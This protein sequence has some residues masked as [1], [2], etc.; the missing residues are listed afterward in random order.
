MKSK[1]P[2]FFIFYLCFCGFSGTL[3]ADFFSIEPSYQD[4]TDLASGG[5][6]LT[7]ATHEGMIFSNPAQ[8]A[9][10]PK[11]FKWL[12]TRFSI[13][14]TQSAIDYATG[15]LPQFSAEDIVN[16]LDQLGK[17]DFAIGAGSM[18][19]TFITSNFAI[20]PI[21][22]DFKIGMGFNKFG[23]SKSGTSSFEASLD[24]ENKSGLGLATSI[25]PTSWLSL[26]VTARGLL[27]TDEVVTI[28]IN[29]GAFAAN[30]SAS[31]EAVNSTIASA[32]D[33]LSVSQVVGYDIG[34]LLF[35]QGPVIDYRF[36]LVAR[37]VGGAKITK[38][39]LA[40]IGGNSE[41]IP[42]QSKPQ[43]FDVGV[44]VTLHSSS[45]FIHLAADLRD[46]KNVYETPS[47]KRYAFGLK[48]HLAQWVALAAGVR[49][50]YPSY[51]IEFDA[52]LF[53]LSLAQYTE[54]LGNDPLGKKRK[55]NHISFAMGM[56][57]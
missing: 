8:L 43:A 48:S 18:L 11:I 5:A 26:G 33:A 44:G 19:L 47:F 49:H 56:D 21:A 55:Y 13:M 20:V 10:G 37:D 7:F 54:V 31:I 51:G 9:I 41:A 38:A 34:S 23:T 46:V 4:P 6:V 42:S 1:L 29:L 35:F 32:Q 28:P 15:K 40:G 45:S 57:F 16:S 17:I 27:V 3:Q 12:G 39:S 50:G 52:I 36:A 30:P 24:V 2:N 14:P 25:M 53:R 22:T